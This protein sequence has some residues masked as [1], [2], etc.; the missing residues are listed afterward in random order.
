MTDRLLFYYNLGSTFLS[1]SLFITI[2][3][4]VFFSTRDF[5]KK[6]AEFVAWWKY[7][8]HCVLLSFIFLILGINWTY[9]SVLLLVEMKFP[10]HECMILPSEHDM[11][12]ERGSIAPSMNFYLFQSVM[13][14]LT[15]I[16]TLCT[17][18]LASWSARRA[19]TDV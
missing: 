16:A 18:S 6:H 15:L 1:C 17:L 2:L 19:K 7:I 8:R 3:V 10:H 11:N 14:Y 13:V 9:V 4:Y 5:V 12:Y